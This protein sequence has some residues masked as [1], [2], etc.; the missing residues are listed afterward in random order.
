MSCK[1]HS[2]FRYVSQECSL[3]YVKSLLKQSQGLCKLSLW[4]LMGSYTHSPFN[5]NPS[6]TEIIAVSFI[7]DINFLKN[8]I[9][10]I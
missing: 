5:D 3:E 6:S 10:L 7:P 1:I 4:S 8:T 2:I 9:Y